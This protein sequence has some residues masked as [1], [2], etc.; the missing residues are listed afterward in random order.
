MLERNELTGG[1]T[2]LDGGAIVAGAAV[3][4]VHL[5]GVIDEP[6]A[7][8][9]W[10]LAWATFALVGLTA[11]GPFLFLYQRLQARRANTLRSGELVWAMLGIPWI[12]TALLATGTRDLT[13]A[14]PDLASN[15][16][17]ISL[18]VA[19]FLSMT[20][21]WSKWVRLDPAGAAENFSGPWTNRVG[22][23][24]AVAWPLQCGMGLVVVG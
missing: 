23:V 16:L 12:V 4:A 3:S 15:W 5:R 10:I 13:R 17:S 9:G 21:L 24:L 20:V 1:F 18:A 19:C 7:G 11:A 14:A 22:L 2:V 8:P 6:F